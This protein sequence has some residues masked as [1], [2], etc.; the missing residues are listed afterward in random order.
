LMVV[1]CAATELAR[2]AKATMDFE[3]I[4]GRTGGICD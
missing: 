3:N 4:L 1:F 2:S